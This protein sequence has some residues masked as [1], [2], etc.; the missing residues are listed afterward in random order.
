[1]KTSLIISCLLLLIAIAPMPYGYYQFLR[2]TITVVTG[3][4]AYDLYQKKQNNWLVAFVAI[5]ILYNP[6]IVI[7]FEKAI[8]KPINIVTA[9]FFGVFALVKKHKD[10]K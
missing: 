10:N 8:W 9:V 7:H 3:I 5:V 6:I 4:Y 2:I 1:M